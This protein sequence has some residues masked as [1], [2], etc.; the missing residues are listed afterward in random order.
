MKFRPVADP[1]PPAPLPQYKVV[2]K[3][4]FKIIT[5]NDVQEVTAVSG[6]TITI[7]S[8]TFGTLT[9]SQDFSNP[10]SWT[11][12]LVNA[13]EATPDG[14]ISGLF[15]LKAGNQVK[16]SGA[17][18]YNTQGTYDR[19]CTVNR[20]ISV[21]VPAGEFD[22]FEIECKM[23]YLTEGYTTLESDIIWYAPKVNH[24]VAINRHS[25]L[26]VLQSYSKK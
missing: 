2:D 10:E 5:V 16:G 23:D 22:T 18:A 12:G 13:Y 15:P 7:R 11:G 1:M 20:Q 4:T 3:F 19:V 21:T 25:R 26:F 24:W 8:S 6:D 17:Y 14:K 9:Q